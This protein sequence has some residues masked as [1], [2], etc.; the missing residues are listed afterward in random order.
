[1]IDTMMKHSL[2]PSLLCAVSGLMITGGTAS[3]TTLTVYNEDEYGYSYI[4]PIFDAS[5]HSLQNGSAL[6]GYLQDNT[7]S[8]DLVGGKIEWSKNGTPAEQLS[9][10]QMAEIRQSFTSS[11][12]A[13]SEEYPGTITNGGQF[14]LSGTLA[15]GLEGKSIVLLID[16][17]NSPGEFSM[18]T[19]RDVTTG[20][21]AKYPAVVGDDMIF[22]FGSQEEAI[23]QGYDWY[24]TPLFN[25]DFHLVIPEPA[26]ATLSLLGLA[27][28][29]MRRRR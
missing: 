19:F 13:V 7:W 12:S 10:S 8:F 17:N 9:Y 4:T 11:L 26:T 16:N 29:M 20:E 1:M 3:A 6:L 23:N 28:L 18:F 15:S 27:A 24:V 25:D 14:S 2:L 5:G 22:F 21:L